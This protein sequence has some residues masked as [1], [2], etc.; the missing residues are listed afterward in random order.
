MAKLMKSLRILRILL[1]WKL[2][3]AIAAGAAVAGCEAHRISPPPVTVAQYEKTL[4]DSS[5]EYPP[6][7]VVVHNLRRVLDPKLSEADRVAS[8]ALVKRLDQDDPDVR[9]QLTGILADEANGESLHLAVLEMLLGK[10]DPTLSAY[11]VRILPG[12]KADSPVREKILAWLGRNPAP[13]V[14]AETVRMW[15][16]EK[17][18]TG[19]E[20]PRFRQTVERVSGKNWDQALLDV[21]NTPDF[22]VAEQAV[23]LLVARI[24]HDK[25][26]A[27]FAA[28][29]ARTEIVRGLQVLIRLFDYFPTSRPAILASVPIGKT[30]Q[31]PLQDAARLAGDWRQ[32]YG[33]IFDVRDFYLI[34]ELARDPMRK[35]LRRTQLILELAQSF[36]KRPHV[37]RKIL[38]ASGPY[39]F[40]D[41][42]SKHVDSL[43]MAD[44]WNLLI[45]NEMISRPRVQM[46]LKQMADRDMADTTS[47]W[48]GLIFYESGQAEAKLYPADT[49]AGPDDLNY[50]PTAQLIRDGRAS[51]CRFFGHFDKVN[52]AARAGPTGDELRRAAEENACG[53]V[54]TRVTADSFCAHYFNPKGL[55]ISLG[56]LPLR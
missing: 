13:G 3:L 47:A 40:S 46:A 18:P 11:A 48:G 44:L 24:P 30:P 2:A 7:T 41:Q 19:L 37:P 27:Q 50:R 51:L 9:N 43:T 52:N 34:N 25:L 26:R 14:L 6:R 10:D 1:T 22:P 55:V 23:E 33:Y 21:A 31:A 39:D 17:S 54:L 20:E 28:L 5:A 16:L 4:G 45:V 53:L 12:L 29:Q 49:S 36:V 38:R 35:N 32:N 42:L 15:A 8:L 56:T